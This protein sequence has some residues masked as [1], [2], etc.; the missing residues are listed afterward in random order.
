MSPS[1]AIRINRS[2]ATHRALRSKMAKQR[3]FEHAA[4]LDKQA[5][6]RWA[7]CDTRLYSSS[8]CV[9]FSQPPI[10]SGDQSNLSFPADG[11]PKPRIDRQFTTF[12]T[13]R[14]CCRYLVRNC[15]PV[16]ITA[17]IAAHFPAHRRGRAAKLFGDGTGRSTCRNASGNHLA[18]RKRQCQPGATPLPR[19]KPSMRGNQ[20]DRSTMTAYQK[21]VRSPSV[22]PP[23]SNGPIIPSFSAA[24]KPL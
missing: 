6:Y 21:L 4:R 5:A 17:A 19:T 18:F 9:L 16:A 2:G 1:I 15:R 23:A 13:T 22:T 11:L 20:K 8:G 24:V 7:L 14:S 3:F 10:C 12:W